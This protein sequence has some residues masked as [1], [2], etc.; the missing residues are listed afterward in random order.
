MA[1]RRSSRKRTE[2]TWEHDRNGVLAIVFGIAAALMLALPAGVRWDSQGQ[3]CVQ[4][5]FHVFHP[6]QPEY[7]CRTTYN[8][9]STQKWFSTERAPAAA[10]LGAVAIGLLLTRKR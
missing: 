6:D 10:I 3:E 7:T 9:G 2:W 1:R 4:D 8:S 5:Y